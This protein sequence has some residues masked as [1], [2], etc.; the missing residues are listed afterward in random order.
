MQGKGKS[1]PKNTP[2]QSPP[3]IVGIV[4]FKKGGNELP[5]RKAKFSCC[6][7]EAIWSG[8]KL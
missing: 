8:I 2:G 3:N 6:S 5:E 7:D 1:K 4:F